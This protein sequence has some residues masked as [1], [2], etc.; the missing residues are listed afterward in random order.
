M[1]LQSHWTD[2][3]EAEPL[4]LSGAIQ[5]HG[6][7]L[8]LNAEGV[9]THASVNL[10][11]YLP[12]LPKDLL[13][14]N[15]PN[16]LHLILAPALNELEKV[17]GSRAELFGISIPHRP[18]VD[19]VLLRNNEGVVIELSE[20]DHHFTRIQ[21]HTVPMKP[22]SNASSSLVL[23]N[24]ITQLI[25]E[26][27]GFDRVMIYAF[28]DDGDGEV[29]A[30]A[31]RKEMEGSYFG[32]RFP[33]SDIPQI[34]RELYKQNPWRL[35]PNCQAPPIPLLSVNASPPDLTW[36]DLRSVSPV[37][38]VYLKNMGVVA[39]LSVPIIVGKELWGLIAC[40]HSTPRVLPLKVM[41]AVSQISKH[42]GLVL[43]T[44]V[45]ETR[46][47]FV[48]GLD[49][50]YYVLRIAMQREGS[51]VSAL[52]EMAHQLFGLFQCDG[53]AIRAGNVWAHT[54][55]SPNTATLEKL[56]EWFECDESESI[57]W[58]DN[59]LR[60]L[61]K[62]SSLPVAGAVAIKLYPRDGSN[63]QVWL[64]RKE[65]VH[66]VEWGGNPDKPVELND[67]EMGIAPRRSFEKW[68]EKRKGYSTPWTGENR[69]AAKRLRQL[70]IE[71]YA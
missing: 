32:L 55:D 63:L 15:L 25:K 54:G 65:L 31:R 53:I 52:P 35:I 57:I 39:S 66:E 5:P 16:E 70:L 36:S 42:Y 3:C 46:M 50:S 26:I 4:A 33:G 11:A 67:G 18:S 56:S 22:P 37:H 2:H 64:F 9:V 34:A 47:R 24:K 49:R 7:L 38:Q 23:H 62:L 17:C 21:P 43:S 6:G 8:F 30:E 20:Y 44:W 68:V 12:Y 48:D 61:P 28:R 14:K 41:R 1:K 10:D 40:H 60:Q 27:S 58:V 45:A 51:I 69:L 71:M 29:L 59:L 19:F 13:G